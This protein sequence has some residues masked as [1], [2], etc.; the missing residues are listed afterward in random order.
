MSRILIVRIV[1]P[2]TPRRPT[3]FSAGWANLNGGL[4][5]ETAPTL[6]GC[7]EWR[8]SPAGSS[9][10]RQYSQTSRARLRTNRAKL[11]GIRSL[12][13]R[14]V[15]LPVRLAAAS[16]TAY[17]PTASE[18]P[19]RDVRGGIAAP[20]RPA[21]RATPEAAGARRA[22]S[23]TCANPSA[24]PTAREPSVPWRLSFALRILAGT[25][26][27]QARWPILLSLVHINSAREGEGREGDAADPRGQ[28]VFPS[29]PCLSAAEETKGISSLLSQSC[30]TDWD[31]RQETGLVPLLRLTR[32][33]GRARP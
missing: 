3:A 1:F 12:M 5:V 24:D 19:L 18:R 10:G 32:Q 2:L 20:A 15:F 23:G 30:A 14:A 25:D 13:M 9:Q 4:S 29:T 11:A 22:A 8:Q 28:T 21:D 31:I 16:A 17:R 27:S 7:N 6:P 26:P 33:G